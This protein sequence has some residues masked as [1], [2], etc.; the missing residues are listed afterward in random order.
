MKQEPVETE[1]PSMLS[2][3][4]INTASPSGSAIN[5]DIIFIDTLIL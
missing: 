1:E 4:A 2:F 5:D 3:R